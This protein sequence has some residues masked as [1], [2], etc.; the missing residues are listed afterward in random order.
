MQH[1]LLT[2]DAVLGEKGYYWSITDKG[3]QF[4]ADHRNNSS[5]T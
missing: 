3:R 2:R 5:G 1:G 4:V